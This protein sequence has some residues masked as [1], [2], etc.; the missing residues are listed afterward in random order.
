MKTQ[1]KSEAPTPA[2]FVKF[3][4]TEDE[5]GS[6]VRAHLYIEFYMDRLIDASIPNPA[7]LPAMRLDYFGRVKLLG[8]L[9]VGDRLT[10]PLQNLGEL[11]NKFAHQLNF[12][13][14]TER[15]RALYE[16]FDANAKQIVHLAYDDMRKLSSK[17]H[18]K[19]MWAL[20]P[21]DIFS[22]LAPAIRAA[23]LTAYKEKTGKL[24]AG[25]WS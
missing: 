18:P 14:T 25:S 24:P 10:K 12:R 20:A 16:T 5:L 9:G 17:N 23:L 22:L 19:K 2:E 7:A 4:M 13:L 6:V 1:K 11:R 15:M 3:L 21:K 8:V